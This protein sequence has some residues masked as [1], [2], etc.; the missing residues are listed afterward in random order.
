MGPWNSN[1]SPHTFISSALY[2]ELSLQPVSLPPG[3]QNG[4]VLQNPAVLGFS[5]RSGATDF[6]HKL[7]GPREKHQ[8]EISCMNSP[9]NRLYSLEEQ[10]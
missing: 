3:W 6:K 4:G 7:W 2:N 5:V 9:K 1:S 10:K 8:S